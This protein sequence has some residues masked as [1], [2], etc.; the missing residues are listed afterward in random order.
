M[1]YVMAPVLTMYEKAGY[2]NSFVFSRI[3]NHYVLSV[4]TKRCNLHPWSCYFFKQYHAVSMKPAYF[5]EASGF[6]QLSDVFG[7]L[8]VK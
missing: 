2:W 7:R 4:S 3:H 8:K 5:L 1:V 6:I